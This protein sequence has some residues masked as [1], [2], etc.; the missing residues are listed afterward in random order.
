MIHD[1]KT[2]PE[3]FD[4]VARNEKTFEIRKDDRGYQVGDALI[5]RRTRYTGEQMHFGSPVEYTGEKEVRRVTHLLRGPLYGLAE[6]WVILSISKDLSKDEVL[7]EALESVA[8]PCGGREASA[9][10]VTVKVEGAKLSVSPVFSSLDDRVTA[11]LTDSS[12]SGL[13]PVHIA[14]NLAERFWREDNPTSTLRD[15]PSMVYEK[16]EKT[17]LRVLRKQYLGA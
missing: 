15:P 3:V 11:A 10:P 5:L 4:A 17:V 8:L 6:G 12:L 7:F 9:N 16:V 2:D 14:I 13:A 1:L